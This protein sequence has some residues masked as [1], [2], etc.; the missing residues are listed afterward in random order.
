MEIIVALRNVA[1]SVQ[2]ARKVH[3]TF[4]HVSSCSVF[5]S[6]D[7][8]SVLHAHCVSDFSLQSFAQNSLSS[9]K[10]KV[11]LNL[12]TNINFFYFHINFPLFCPILRKYGTCNKLP[13]IRFSK[14]PFV[15]TR[16]VSRLQT[17]GPT[18]WFYWCSTN[19]T[20]LEMVKGS[21]GQRV[22]LRPQVEPNMMPSQNDS[23]VCSYPHIHEAGSI[24]S[25]RNV[26][27]LVYRYCQ[28][29][30]K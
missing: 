14:H 15:T 28:R 27:L 2:N 12:W 23:S 5:L 17:D 18:E 7:W 30:D 25:F 19:T 6:T 24:I 8:H 22:I 10:Q 21:E 3:T 13:C 26:V 1:E 9:S 4:T 20:I 16:I 29:H 11:M